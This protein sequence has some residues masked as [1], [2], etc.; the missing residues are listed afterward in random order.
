MMTETKSIEIVRLHRRVLPPLSFGA[1]L[2]SHLRMRS[3]I[4]A[5]STPP[6]NLILRS[7]LRAVSKDA[8]G[9]G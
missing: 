4:A 2:R 3:Q 8:G 1:C 6:A 9:T 7:D 5:L